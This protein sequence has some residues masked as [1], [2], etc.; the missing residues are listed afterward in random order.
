[1]TTSRPEIDRLYVIGSGAS[2]PYGLPT[3]KTLTWELCNFLP[4]D[5]R[6]ILLAAIYE[7]IGIDMRAAT[8]NV[9]FEELLDRLNPRALFY[10]TTDKSQEIRIQAAEIALRGLREFMIRKC[11]DVATTVGPYDRLVRSLGKRD[12]IVSFNWDVLP[13]LAF[14][15]NAV[16]YFYWRDARGNVLL[17]PHGSIN[18]F[19]LLDRELLSVDV[20]TTNW[21][22]FGH[23]LTYYLLFLKD[24]LGSRDLGGS[25]EFVEHALAQVPAIV[26]PIASKMLSV[27]G[28]PRDSFVDSGH[29]RAMQSIW[30]TFHQYVHDATQLVFIG[31]SLPGTEASSISVLR[32]F[33]PDPDGQKGKRVLIVDKSRTVVDRYKRLIHPDS[34]LVCDDFKSFDPTSV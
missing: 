4:T 14:R 5:D 17:K 7:C 21:D 27:G 33:A 30:K 19:A 3:L 22:V 24:P 16:P 25:S 29:Q 23:D 1:M 34:A 15:R 11:A 2:D 31:Y 9:D 18:W 32:N 8:D 20:R 26:P 13:E 10:L 12:A 6:E 28:M